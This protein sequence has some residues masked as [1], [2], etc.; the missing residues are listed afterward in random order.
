MLRISDISNIDSILAIYPLRFFYHCLTIALDPHTRIRPGVRPDQ[1]FWVGVADDITSSDPEP[2][3]CHLESLALGLRISSD[4]HLTVHL[5]FRYTDETH[6]DI[7]DCGLIVIPTRNILGS[8]YLDTDSNTENGV[9]TP[10]Y[11]RLRAFIPSSNHKAVQLTFSPHRFPKTTE[12]EVVF[13]L[14]DCV[15]EMGYVRQ[16]IVAYHSMDRINRDSSLTSAN[17]TIRPKDR[18]VQDDR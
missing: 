15:A 11:H 13:N 3:G 6:R 1:D 8:R 17:K 7:R 5:A 12:A 16:W 4:D 9:Y 10:L 2:A 18:G 14:S